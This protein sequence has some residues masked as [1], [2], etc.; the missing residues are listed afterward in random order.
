MNRPQVAH[1]IFKTEELRHILGEAYAFED[2]HVFAA[3]ENERLARLR[4]YLH[5]LFYYVIVFC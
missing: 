4:V 2:A 5:D 1:I 3:G